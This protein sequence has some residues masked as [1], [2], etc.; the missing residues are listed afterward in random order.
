MPQI[1]SFGALPE[2]NAH[3]SPAATKS[4]AASA[5]KKAT[6]SSPSSSGATDETQVSPLQSQLTRLSSVLNGLQKNANAN[7]AQ[8]VQALSKV[9]SGTYTIDPLDVSRSIVNDLLTN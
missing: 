7:R 3:V 4:A 9:K 2:S 6:I 1:S 5:A 8:Y